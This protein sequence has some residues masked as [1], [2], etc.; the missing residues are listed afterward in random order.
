[1]RI[2]LNVLIYVNPLV[3]R[4]K[5]D[6]FKFPFFFFLSFF[7]LI[8]TCHPLETF[9]FFFQLKLSSR[10]QNICKVGP[11][12]SMK[13]DFQEQN[14]G[15]HDSIRNKQIYMS[16]YFQSLYSLNTL[17][18]TLEYTIL[19]IICLKRQKYTVIYLF[20]DFLDL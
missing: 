11:E 4:Q 19:S 14:K 2:K 7:S 3:Q 9:F 15:P 16:K 17:V 20:Q 5:L 1:M 12:D 8:L 18:L 6:K 13:R 10:D